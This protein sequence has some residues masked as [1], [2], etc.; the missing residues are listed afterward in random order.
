MGE[1]MMSI[2]KRISKEIE[3]K[4]NEASIPLKDFCLLKSNRKDLGEFQIN[5][6]MALA[7]VMKKAPLCIAEELKKVLESLNIFD[8]IDYFNK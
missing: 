7:K 6:A 5:D 8:K 1:D 2:L 3:Q 4:A